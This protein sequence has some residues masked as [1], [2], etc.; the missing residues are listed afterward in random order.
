MPD[1]YRPGVY[2]LAGFAVGAVERDELLDGSAVAE[3]DVLLGLPSSGLHSNGY[4][5]AR[6]IFG[7]PQEWTADTP[8]AGL[9]RPLGEVLLEPTRIYAAAVR[10]LTAQPG[11]HA[12]AHITGGGLPA[13][14]ARILPPALQAR[15]RPESWPTPPI[16]DLMARRGPV[17]PAEMHRT[18]NMGLGFVAA[19]DPA[20]AEGAE[21]ALAAAGETVHRVGEV[22]ARPAGEAAVRIGEVEDGG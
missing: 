21:Q 16:F 6:R 7:D 1:F 10:A 4:S 18:F 14:L 17:E 13:N 11:V 19:L 2:D 22:A 15:L 12:M 20:A 9:G 8:E 3:G 5:L